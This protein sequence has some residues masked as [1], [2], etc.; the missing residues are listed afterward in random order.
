[1]RN[2]YYRKTTTNYQSF[3]LR[4][5]RFRKEMRPV[6]YTWLG[7]TPESCVLDAGCGSGVFTRYLAGGLTTGH[8]TGFDINEAFIAYGQTKAIADKM[9]LAVADGY[10]LPYTDNTFDAVT[11]YT[12]TGVLADPAAGLA[13]MIRVCKNGGT[14][15]CVVASNALPT[16]GRQGTYP[17][18]TDGRLDILANRESRI[19]SGLHTS[20]P[21]DGEWQL[22]QNAGLQEIHMYPFAHLIC[23]NDSNFPFAYR[24]D[25]ALAETQ[26]EINWLQSRY[27]ANQAAYTENGFTHEDYC[28][29]LALHKAKLSYLREHFEESESFEW[30]GGYNY[31]ITGKKEECV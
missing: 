14:V 24:K 21:Q 20:S 7:I 3:E 1:M 8:I 26:E 18:D 23:Y 17:F 25:L 4:A 15:S 22:F 10:A 2:N 27:A 11:N 28:G 12:Y 9:T 30:H 13:E 6:F 29:L 19:F 5:H 31:I 16:A